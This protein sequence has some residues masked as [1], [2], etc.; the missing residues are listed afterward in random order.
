MKSDKQQEPVG[1]EPALYEIDRNDLINEWC[2]QMRLRW[3]A[4]KRLAEA[5][6]EHER[7]KARQKVVY[8]DVE[9]AIRRAPQDYRLSVEPKA[10][11]E[12]AIKAT[13]EVQ[14]EVK[15][16]NELTITSKYAVDIAQ[17]ECDVVDDRRHALE[18]IVKL[19]LSEWYAEPRVPKSGGFDPANLEKLKN[20]V[21]KQKK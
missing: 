9:L 10:P 20:K 14:E 11:T 15:D 12:G 8:S 5:R 21:G 1:D 7:A 19:G 4:G 2:G 6:Q 3:G 18:N 13:V 16:V 17:A